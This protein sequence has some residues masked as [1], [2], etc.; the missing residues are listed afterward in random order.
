M[1]LP[2]RNFS[3]V[4]THKTN[5]GTMFGAVAD[6]NSVFIPAPLAKESAPLIVGDTVVMKCVTNTPKGVKAGAQWKA[7]K[8]DH[9]LDEAMEKAIA[10]KVIENFIGDDEPDARALPDM[11]KALR[12][13]RM[14][15]L[16]LKI[17]QP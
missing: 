1:N 6:G 11:I 14:L 2:W 8:I 3:V 5:N 12:A 15:E 16:K 9:N 17:A 13:A 10:L 7:I 4:V